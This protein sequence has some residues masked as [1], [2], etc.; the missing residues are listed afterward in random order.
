MVVQFENV[1]LSDIKWVV[2]FL[3]TL[4][5]KYPLIGF[6]GQLGAGKTTLIRELVEE[7]GVEKNVANSPTFAI[8]NEYKTANNQKVI[9]IDAYRLANEREALD[10]GIHEYLEGSNIVLLIEWAE[11]I[12]NL[13]S[14]IHIVEVKIMNTMDPLARKIIIELPHE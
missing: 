6:Y 1:Y 10:A 4:T 5:S 11:K 13:L 14:D 2:K 7:L 3:A 9:H 12:K 8:I